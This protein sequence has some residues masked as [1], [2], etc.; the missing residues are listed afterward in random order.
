MN[1]GD[2]FYWVLNMSLAASVTAAVV[3]LLRCIKGIPRRV[4][5][6]LWMIP[7]IRMVIP[8]G[9]SG[10]YS[11]MS[12]ISRFTTRTV[13]VYEKSPVKVTATNCIMAAEDYFPITYKINIIEDVMSI[14]FYIWISVSIAL[15]AA[16]L[17]IYY[18]TIRELRSAV[19]IR[20]NIFVSDRVNTPSVYGIIRPRI[21]FPTEDTDRYVLL[22]EGKH[23]KRGD[24]FC[25]ILAITVACIHWFNPLVWILLKLYLAD[26][27]L[28]CDE[29]VLTEL[30]REEHKDYA[31]TL[32]RYT[33]AGTVYASAFGG[34]G[35]RTRIE[36]ILSFKK[37]SLISL[38]AFITLAVF[39]AYFL[40][41][42]S[43][44]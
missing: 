13:T 17:L 3:M 40:L 4:I 11:L 38:I 23:I 27:E 7:L 34:T 21:I 28:A 30:P 22:H 19:H 5:C 25:R 39:T 36:R 15:I 35:I 24:N 14:S 18:A 12:F 41:T 32:L 10:R 42:N 33:E 2:V 37:L 9:I 16:L 1:V 44:G 6:I 43:G 26:T 29:A 31:M 20:E 8:V